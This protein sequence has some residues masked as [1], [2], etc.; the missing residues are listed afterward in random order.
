MLLESKGTCA[1]VHIPWP[2]SGVREWK[3]NLR[4]NSAWVTGKPDENLDGAI[5]RVFAEDTTATLDLDD[6]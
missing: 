3:V 2:G 6:L 5:E 4:V 1:I